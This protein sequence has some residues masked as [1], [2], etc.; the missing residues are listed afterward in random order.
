MYPTSQG[1]SF[2]MD[3][4]LKT[5]VPMVGARCQTFGL[6]EAKV[7]RGAGAPGGGAAAYS[8]IALL[9]FGSAEEFQR[10]I[11]QHGKE[12]MGDIPKFTNINPV[13]QINDVLV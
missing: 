11:E 1:A 5:H 12:I 6:S 4:Y 13:I 3:Y 10:A 7:L 2:D 8:V 9:T